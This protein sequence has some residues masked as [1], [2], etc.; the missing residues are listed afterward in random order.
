MSLSEPN[1]RQIPGARSHA[2]WE[3]QAAAYFTG[4]R[5]RR[6]EGVRKRGWQVKEA[7]AA[8]WGGLWGWVKSQVEKHMLSH[9]DGC[10]VVSN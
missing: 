10:S 9:G 4:S 1:W 2:S 7:G 3:W 5:R 8:A 6:E